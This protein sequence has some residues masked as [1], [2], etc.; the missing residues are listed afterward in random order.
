MLATAT[1]VEATQV[2]PS[3]QVAA[4]YFL[5]GVQVQLTKRAV[6]A[7]GEAGAAPR[8]AGTVAPAGRRARPVSAAAPS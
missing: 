6:E 1:V 2:S 4:V 8:P 5:R 7:A 3:L